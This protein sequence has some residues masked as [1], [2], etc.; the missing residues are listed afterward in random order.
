MSFIILC[1]IY[2]IHKTRQPSVSEPMGR[3]QNFGRKAILSVSRHN[4]K[5][6]GLLITSSYYFDKRINIS[7]F[8]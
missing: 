8:Y 1:T 6:V 2:G 5:Y 7:I 3:D 4:F